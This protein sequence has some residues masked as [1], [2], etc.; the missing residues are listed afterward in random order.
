M[1]ANK[2]LN[3]PVNGSYVNDWDVP[4][5]ANWNTIDQAFGGLT[6]INVVGASGTIVLT[7]SQYI[8]PNFVFE[9][10]LTA[11]V[12]YQ[13]PLNVGGIWTIEN[14]TTGNYTVTFASVST[15]TLQIPQGY[16]TIAVSNGTSVSPG[17]N[18]P[19]TITSSQVISAL[20]YTPANVAGDTFTGPITV[21]GAVVTTQN[22]DATTVSGANF[23]VRIRGDSGGYAILQFTDNPVSRQWSTITATS[24]GVIS[25]SGALTAAGTITATTNLI[26]GTNATRSGN[27]VFPYY[28]DSGNTSG[29]ITVST[30]APSGTPGNGDLWL[31]HN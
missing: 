19:V 15:P 26:V 11:D 30:A 14:A 21:D 8:S 25:T 4:V 16:R 18:V 27:G 13:L 20:G 22:V 7:P 17:Y 28:S 3:T 2:N 9:G 23:G 6:I 24:N 12:T 31:Q 5:N 1:T 29:V 10:A